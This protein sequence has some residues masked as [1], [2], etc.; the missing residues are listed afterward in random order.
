MTGK[1]KITVVAFAIVIIAV[2]VILYNLPDIQSR[3]TRNEAPSEDF[4]EFFTGF[5]EAPDKGAVLDSGGNDFTD[6]FYS[7]T[8]RYYEAGDFMSIKDYMW[9]NGISEVSR[10]GESLQDM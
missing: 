1:K 3:M 7:A 4:V 2:A 10:S 6:D 9:D 5:Y 8:V